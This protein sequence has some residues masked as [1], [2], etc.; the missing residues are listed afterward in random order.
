MLEIVLNLSCEEN[1]KKS[2]M[3]SLYKEIRG[4]INQKVYER[5]VIYIN[6]SKRKQSYI[7]LD[8]RWNPVSKMYFCFFIYGIPI[9]NSLFLYHAPVHVKKR[10][11]AVAMTNVLILNS[12]GGDVV[13][14]HLLK[15]KQTVI[16]KSVA[17]KRY[18][19]NR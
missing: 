5:K 4:H 19:D 7:K 8:F 3:K 2:V 18:S 17:I 15:S 6:N 16:N 10:A 9:Q 14:Y 11:T 1:N 13:I 12:I